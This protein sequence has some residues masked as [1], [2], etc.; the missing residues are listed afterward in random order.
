MCGFQIPVEVA[1]GLW[2]REVVSAHTTC[3]SCAGALVPFK[4]SACRHL[5]LAKLI[6]HVDEGS[7]F[8][9]LAGLKHIIGDIW[10]NA[11]GRMIMSSMNTDYTATAVTAAFIL[12]LPCRMTTSFNTNESNYV[13]IRNWIFC[14]I[15]INKGIVDPS[16]WGS[17]NAF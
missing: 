8:V 1:Q 4:L 6:P 7:M 15:T 17:M 16:R 5:Y 2:H 11:I 14:H 13:L 10:I 12:F 3:G 9:T